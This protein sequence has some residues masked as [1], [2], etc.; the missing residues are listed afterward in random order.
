VTSQGTGIIINREFS[1]VDGKPKMLLEAM[2]I[3]FG[4]KFVIAMMLALIFC[5]AKL[6]L[7]R[8]QS[9]IAD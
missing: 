2:P 9:R 8:I 4:S 3:E 5:V 6:G 7:F 1:G